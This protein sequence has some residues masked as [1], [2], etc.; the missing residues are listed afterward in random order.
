MGS[1]W[2]VQSAQWNSSQSS[3]STGTRRHLS[4]HLH[5]AHAWE[6]SIT[7]SVLSFSTN[8]E[9][10]LEP[11][12]DKSHPAMTGSENDAPPRGRGTRVMG[13]G[14]AVRGALVPGCL[15]CPC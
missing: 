12:A 6:Q 10:F 2:R 1:S 8:L 14:A 7:D 5:C 3:S 15:R 11:E 4:H 13:L 9:K